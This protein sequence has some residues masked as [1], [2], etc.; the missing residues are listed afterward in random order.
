MNGSA[1]NT[2]RKIIGGN[3]STVIH[4][5][6]ARHI[7]TAVADIILFQKTSLPMHKIHHRL[8]KIRTRRMSREK[9]RNAFVAEA[10]LS[11]CSHQ[12]NNYNSN[13]NHYVNGN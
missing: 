10:F 13:T 1:I 4:S 3:V 12:E 6:D 2:R 11:Y 9:R 5:A 7:Y 8:L